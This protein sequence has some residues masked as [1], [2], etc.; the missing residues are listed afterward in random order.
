MKKL[1]LLLV[2]TLSLFSA[3]EFKDY[4]SGLE[5][6]QKNNRSLLVVV[7]QDHCP[8]CAKFKVTLADKE[9]Q[10][11]LN[12]KFVLVFLNKDEKLPKRFQVSM[13]PVSFIVDNTGET[14]LEVIGYATPKKLL[15]DLEMAFEEL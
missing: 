13:T 12:E 5:Y 10:K 1:L 14:L 4:K 2:F 9:V 7:E 6:A 11:V 8:W 15:F 3:Q